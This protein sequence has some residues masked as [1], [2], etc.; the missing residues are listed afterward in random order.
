MGQPPTITR[1]H[2]LA[3][4]G[5][6]LAA[7][8]I[9]ARWVEPDRVVVTRHMIGEPSNGVPALRLVQLTD[10]HLQ[11]VGAHEERVAR[12]VRGLAPDILLLTGDA[13]DRR[14]R[15]EVLAG[16]LTLL[17]RSIPVYATLGN[18]EHWAEVDLAGLAAVY[19]RHGARL[20][21][22]ESIRVEHAGRAMLLT[23]LDDNTAGRPDLSLAL[24]GTE[25]APNHLLLAHSPVYR[26]QLARTGRA[27]GVDLVLS[28]H[29]HG[30]QV[31]LLGW[32]PLRPRGSGRYVN[33]WYRD[34]SPHLYVSRGIGTSV[35]PVRFGAPP[36]VACFSWHLRA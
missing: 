2:F 22:N 5:A 23:G 34:R 1:R 12:A 25:H 7:L 15:L 30:G 13:I 27:E 20:L 8:G 18:W 3:A 10:L 19:G 16:F 33:G 14:D 9:A 31:Q 32:A 29:T 11:G 36:E 6:G 35:L 28:G 21:V 24:A 17:P 26:D 4:G